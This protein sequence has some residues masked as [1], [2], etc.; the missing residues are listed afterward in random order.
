MK[1]NGYL[2][3]PSTSSI[4]D[5]LSI[6]NSLQQINQIKVTHLYVQLRFYIH[7]MKYRLVYTM[8]QKPK[9]VSKTI[10]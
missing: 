5:S 6:I 8:K 2:G 4:L 9:L 3:K 10:R 7:K 1:G